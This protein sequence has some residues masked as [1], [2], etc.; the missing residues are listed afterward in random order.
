MQDQLGTWMLRTSISI[1]ASTPKV[2]I[3]YVASSTNTAEVLYFSCSQNGSTTSAQDAVGL[4]VPA[5]VATVTAGVTT[6]GA[7]ATVIDMAGGG[8]PP[9]APPCPPTPG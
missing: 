7:T 3:Q 1:T 4:I 6:P 5:S 2:A 8:R 9:A